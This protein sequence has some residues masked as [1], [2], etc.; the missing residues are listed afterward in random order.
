M[1]RKWGQSGPMEMVGK[2]PFFRDIIVFQQRKMGGTV[3]KEGPCPMDFNP[4]D[5]SGMLL[6]NVDI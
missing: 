6:Q 5:G 1:V 2:W 4:G 3:R